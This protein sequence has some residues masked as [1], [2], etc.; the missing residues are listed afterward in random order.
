MLSRCVHYR[1]AVVPLV[2]TAGAGAQ[3]VAAPGWMMSTYAPVKD[4]VDLAFA[5]NG[6]LF[7]GRDNAGSG[8][9]NGDAVKIHRIGPGGSPVE[10]YGKSAVSDPDAVGFDEVGAV[11]GT[12]GSVLIGGVS[13]NA[14]RVSFV[15]PDGTVGTL[16][17]LQKPLYN[18]CAFKFNGAG[19]LFMGDAGDGN[20]DS[21]V[22]A[23]DQ[24]NAMKVLIQLADPG[25]GICLLPGGRLL[26]GSKSGRVDVYTTQGALVQGNFADVW[27][28]A[29]FEGAKDGVFLSYAGVLKGANPGA[30]LAIREDGS[31]VP[32]ATGFAGTVGVA[33]VEV[34]SDKA[35]YASDFEG[36]RIVRITRCSANC[37]G[38]GSLDLF[39]FLCFVNKFNA[40]DPYADFDVNGE[41]DLF[42]FLAFVNAFNAGCEG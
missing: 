19:R 3:P 21:V 1:V 17:N 30:V 29:N 42:D 13:G 15:K 35:V 10:E 26:A 22:G 14:G 7:V 28:F 12:P 11:T 27:E 40:A 8:G 23:T 6:A 33:G 36:D 39:D 41:H 5:P 18:P 24:A 9:G 20:A 25:A 31:V 16:F 2:L 37:D 4:P 32:A 34:G 38:N